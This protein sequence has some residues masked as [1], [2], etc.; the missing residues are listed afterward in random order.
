[1]LILPLAGEEES[2][3]LVN[4]LVGW[5]VD[6]DVVITSQVSTARRGEC[7]GEIPLSPGDASALWSS[8]HIAFFISAIRMLMAFP[9]LCLE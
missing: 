7:W 1:M 6:G 4:L 8:T 9:L 5:E 3:L 2:P